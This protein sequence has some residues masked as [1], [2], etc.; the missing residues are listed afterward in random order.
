MSWV[1]FVKTHLRP[2]HWQSGTEVF[3]EDKMRF[4]VGPWSEGLI[5]VRSKTTSSEGVEVGGGDGEEEGE[6][7]KKPG[8][9]R[10]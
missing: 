8:R 9:Y 4:W 7:E 5:L 10:H 6:G 3:H 2:C 1:P